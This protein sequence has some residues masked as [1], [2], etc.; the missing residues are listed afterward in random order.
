MVVCLDDEPRIL[1][2]LVRLL[3]DEP[4]E[5]LATDQPDRALSWILSREV[6]V[7]MADYRMPT[8]D[9]IT[10]LEMVQGISPSSVRLLLTG[11]PGES[12]ILKSR[13][14]GL[15]TIIAKPW[16]NNQLRR[17]IREILF[18]ARRSDLPGA[19]QAV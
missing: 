19:P 8:I 17:M 12:V 2:S 9:G 13:N 16:D 4:L 1:S 6:R 5:L 15:L 18:G 14:Q 11:Y 3:R 7:V 10:F